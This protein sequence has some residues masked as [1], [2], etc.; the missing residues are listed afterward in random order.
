MSVI[1]VRYEASDKAEICTQLLF[2]D[3]ITV[4]K[5]SEDGKWAYIQQAQDEYLGWIDAK[6][7]KEI[8]KEQ[9]YTCLQQPMPISRGLFGL[10]K[11]QRKF[12]PILMGSTLPMYHAGVI[13]IGEEQ[14]EFEGEHMY[15]QLGNA[16]S[17]ENYARNFLGAPYLWG[18]KSH[19]GIDCSGLVQ[20]VFKLNN[21]KLPRDSY[22][23]AEVGQTVTYGAHQAGDLAFFQNVNGRIIH[24]GIVLPG[25]QII[26]ASGEVRIDLLDEVGIFHTEKKIYTHKLS[27][28]KRVL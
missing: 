1:P 12:F 26:H 23:Q 14:F 24:V 21:I 11:G 25:D 2:G 17:V 3:L 15:P 4:N 6:Q 19:F 7:Y 28:L 18:G 10:I 5:I 16:K 20:Q 27:L 8:P 22:K 9:Y 13:R